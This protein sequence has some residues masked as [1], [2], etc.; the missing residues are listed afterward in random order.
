[1]YIEYDNKS[2]GRK[3]S[4]KQKHSKQ[5]KGALTGGVKDASEGPGGGTGAMQGYEHMIGGVCQGY[6]DFILFP[7]LN[8]TLKRCI[9]QGKGY[10]IYIYSMYNYLL[11][12]IEFGTINMIMVGHH[13][14]LE[15]FAEH[16]SNSKFQK[17]LYRENIRNSFYVN[18]PK[19]KYNVARRGVVVLQQLIQYIMN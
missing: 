12:Y 13:T 3:G 15:N 11:V 6:I 16:H 7:Q 1:M 5:K 9:T 18:T 2:N 10:V 17:Q 14:V 4:R 19:W 8:Q